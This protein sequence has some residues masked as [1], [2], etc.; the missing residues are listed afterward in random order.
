MTG[1][2]AA[3]LAVGC[4]LFGLWPSRRPAAVASAWILVRRAVRV[5]HVI[6]RAHVGDYVSWVLIGFTVL[7]ATLMI[8]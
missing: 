3:L 4:A 1:V 7:G 2:V 8:G 5:L 6:H